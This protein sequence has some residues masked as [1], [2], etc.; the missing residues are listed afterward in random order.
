V[1][2]RLRNRFSDRP[3]DLS[4]SVCGETRTRSIAG[5]VQSDS[6]TL[7]ALAL[8]SRPSQLATT[9]AAASPRAL[10][11]A[12]S[13]AFYCTVDAML[14]L[15]RW[16]T[17]ELDDA[18]L[19]AE[20]APKLDATR[21]SWDRPRRLR[22]AYADGRSV[23]ALLRDERAGSRDTIRAMRDL[24]DVFGISLRHAKEIV[25]WCSQPERDAES[26]RILAHASV[27]APR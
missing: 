5:D 8:T 20:L 25:G 3:L 11:L 12:F 15:A 27:T 1:E 17:C 2:T 26:D 18:A 21:H 16:R 23:A 10:V 7:R 4:A 14:A 9:L 13:T 24:M 6:D 22:E 19:D